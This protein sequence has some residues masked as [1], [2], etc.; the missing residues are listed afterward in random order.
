[1]EQG[2]PHHHYHRQQELVLSHYQYGSPVVTAVSQG[3][4]P[5]GAFP[6][7]LNVGSSPSP[8]PSPTP[9]PEYPPQSN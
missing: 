4:P 7:S 6:D 8:L 1:M 9:S 3:A 2:R 5:D